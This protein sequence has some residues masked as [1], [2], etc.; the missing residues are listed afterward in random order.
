MALLQ[1]QMYL[2]EDKKKGKK[3]H[4]KAPNQNK[5]TKKKPRPKIQ[6]QLSYGKITSGYLASA[7][8]W[9]FFSHFE[10]G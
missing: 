6:E 8:F 1:E 9:G 3:T 2:Y 10:N 4:K 5:Q 7:R